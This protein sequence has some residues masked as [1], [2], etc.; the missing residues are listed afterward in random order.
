M[1]CIY[2]RFESY[3]EHMEKHKKITWDQKYTS[4]LNRS[5]QTLKTI[6]KSEHPITVQK[7]LR[8]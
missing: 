2:P 8:Q 7:Q 6:I 5:S 4:K 1:A 3:R